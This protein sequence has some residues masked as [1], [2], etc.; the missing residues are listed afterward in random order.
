M[1]FIFL[2][3]F[4]ID[5]A[6]NRVQPN[7]KVEEG[8]KQYSR[9]QRDSETGKRRNANNDISM[10]HFARE[11]PTHSTTSVLGDRKPTN[12]QLGEGEAIDSVQSKKS[13]FD[14]DSG[15]RPSKLRQL[16]SEVCHIVLLFLSN[17]VK[18]ML[19]AAEPLTRLFPLYDLDA[20][21]R[22][23]F[24]SHNL[25]QSAEWKRA[26]KHGSAVVGPDVNYAKKVH[27]VIFGPPPPPP[28][29]RQQ[30]REENSW[31]YAPIDYDRRRFLKF[32]TS[33]PPPFGN[34][35]SCTHSTLVNK[36]LTCANCKYSVP[37]SFMEFV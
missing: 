26:K 3:L 2:L 30:I 1:P 4:L 9:Y 11:E 20:Y 7:D 13:F 19:R 29:K 8:M 35:L 22:F 16:P 27:Y 31:K 6:V 18:L 15:K 28:S 25:H 5:L 34:Q 36:G 10:V 17:E 21:F 33:H 14:V 12:R 32:C 23:L 24:Q 37:E